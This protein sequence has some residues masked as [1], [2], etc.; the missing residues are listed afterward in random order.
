MS[1]S[2]IEVT[3]KK[4][5]EIGNEPFQKQKICFLCDKYSTRYVRINY[6]DDGGSAYICGKCIKKIYNKMEGIE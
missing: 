3:F 2:N 5:E 4:I 6:I 1:K